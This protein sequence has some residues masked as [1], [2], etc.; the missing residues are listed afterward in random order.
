MKILSVAAFA[1]MAIGLA[2]PVQAF[3]PMEDT[4]G[5][6]APKKFK[7]GQKVEPTATE[8]WFSSSEPSALEPL[9]RK[10]K[11]KK[12]AR[13]PAKMDGGG[14]PYISPVKPKT[15]SFPNSYGSGTIVI[16]TASRRLY[17]VLSSSS[18]YSYPI[19]VG[20]QGFTW[21]GTKS[22]TRK[23][24]WPDWRPP[25]EMLQ[26]R[27]DLPEFMTGGVRNPMGAAALYLGS[28]L[29]R[30]H[31]TNDVKTIGQA[32]SSGC[33]RMTNGH[34]MHLA[35]IAGVGTTVRVL[36]RLPS[37]IARSAKAGYDG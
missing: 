28:S 11:S 2:T 5:Y 17:Y 24:S 16:D 1:V 27:P 12:T 23:V 31:G 35:Q 32:A 26:R 7:R 6:V 22:I 4:Y 21:T 25:A 10:K 33:F 30:I 37:N 9:S 15:V 8:S 13:G 14:K 34:V 29:Y 36:N 18:A 19:S 20:R 3:H